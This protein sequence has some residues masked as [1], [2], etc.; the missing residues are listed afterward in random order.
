[1][2]T[3]GSNETILA[4]VGKM[5]SSSFLLVCSDVIKTVI[6][7]MLASREIEKLTRSPR[8]KLGDSGRNKVRLTRERHLRPTRLCPNEVRF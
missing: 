2:K 8:L 7:P 1:M 6:E 5:D 4:P 3:K